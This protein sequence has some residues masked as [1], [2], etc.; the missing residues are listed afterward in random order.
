M[1]RAARLIPLAAESATDIFS[2]F[3]RRGIRVD[4]VIRRITPLPDYETPWLNGRVSNGYWNTRENR[5]RYL[6]WLGEQ[7]GYRKPEDWY[8]LRKHNFQKNY[9]GGLLR[10]AYGS[11]VQM[12]VRDLMPNYDWHPWLFGGAPNG[13]WKLRE[14]RIQYL[15]WLGDQL[16][17]MVPDDWYCVTGTDFFSNHGGGLLNNEFKGSVQA[18]LN[19]Y[20]PRHP[21]KAWRFHSVPQSYWACIANRRSYLV[22]LGQ[23][24]GFQTAG[25]WTSLRRE[26]FNLNGGSG[27]FVGYYKGSTQRARAELFADESVS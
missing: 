1:R 13:F 19:D 15:D 9:G 16:E 23:Q 6:R 10:N 26:H 21:W 12:A 27:L 14:N 11:S 2:T 3:P 20:M 25:D 4:Q 18:V 8:A 17:I 5:I 24:L 7:C 22:W